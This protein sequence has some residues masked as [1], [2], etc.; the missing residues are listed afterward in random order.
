[1]G[2][3]R[4]MRIVHV[5]RRGLGEWADGL[6]SLE[7]EIEYPLDAD[8][9]TIDHGDDYAAFFSKIGEAHFLVALD[10][11]VVA[12]TI[13]GVFKNVHIGTR[14]VRSIYVADLKVRRSYRGHGV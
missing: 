8:R 9:F 10:G 11:D 2:P 14:Y 3:R 4:L 6:R 1:M 12:G 5:D 13:A 7:R